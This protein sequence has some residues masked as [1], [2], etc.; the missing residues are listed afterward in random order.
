MGLGLVPT[1]N[2]EKWWTRLNRALDFINA[3]HRVP[4]KL[5]LTGTEESKIAKWCA[6]PSS[7]IAFCVAN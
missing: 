2:E 1:T 7:S 5:R 6:P 4:R 3:N